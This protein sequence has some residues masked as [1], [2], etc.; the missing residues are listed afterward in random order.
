MTSTTAISEA[1]P[2]RLSVAWP[3]FAGKLAAA[4]R[5]LRED[6]YLVISTKQ[7]NRFV[8]F[9]GQGSFGLRVEAVSNHYL[10]HADQLDAKQIA[11]LHE[12]GWHAPTGGAPEAV[13]ERDPDGSPNFFVDCAK[14]VPY[15]A[16]AELAVRTLIEVLRVPHPGFL[17]YDSF[18]ADNHPL[19]WPRLGL[20]RADEAPGAAGLPQRLLTTVRLVTGLTE[21]DYDADGDLMLRY[22]STAVQIRLVGQP[23]YVRIASP[24]VSGVRKT[25]R[26]LE[27]INELNAA[28][29][30]PHY[31]AGDG[32]IWSVTDVP[33]APYVHQ[34][35][36]EALQDF[37]RTNDA[38]DELLQAEFGGHTTF[39]EAMPSAL[40]H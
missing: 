34:H 18:D 22:G 37:C 20:K 21:L 38:I 33:A 30:H 26:L 1:T 40:K 36:A 15:A 24:L 31:V 25:Q 28:V 11:A 23:P 6:Q 12:L 17:Q 4:L 9:A 35:V 2:R 8:Q 14:P 19:R 3:P 29:G 5:Q 7:S 16:V 10:S 27:R 32:V 13:P 39:V